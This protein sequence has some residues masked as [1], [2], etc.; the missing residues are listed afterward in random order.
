[1]STARARRT[2]IGTR[3]CSSYV[4]QHVA[5][6]LGLDNGF[7]LVVNDGRDGCQSVYV[8]A[9]A[10]AGAERLTLLFSLDLSC[11]YHLHVHVLGGRQLNWPPG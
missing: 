11:R 8:T 3:P 10:F 2:A 1:M 5:A 9:G 7:R 4:A 6:R